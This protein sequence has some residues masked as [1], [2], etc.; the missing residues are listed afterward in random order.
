LGAIKVGA[1][2]E[3]ARLKRA[4]ELALSEL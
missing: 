3:L 4:H 1:R 2:V